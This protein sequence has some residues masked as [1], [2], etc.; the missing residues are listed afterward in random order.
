MRKVPEGFDPK[1]LVTVPNNLVTVF[2]TLTHDLSLPLPWPKPANYV[3]E[4]VDAP[5]L[6]WGG[7]SSVGQ[8]AIQVLK[9]WGYS[10]I[11]TTASAKHHELLKSLGAKTAVDYRSTDFAEKILDAAG[12]EGL[13]WVVDS[14]GS[15]EGSLKP[16]SQVAKNGTTVAVM[17]PVIVKDTTQG[18]GPI[19]EMDPTEGIEWAEGAVVKGVRTHFYLEVCIPPISQN[20]QANQLSMQNK[21][22]ADHLQSEIIPTLIKEGI[23]KP[24]KY[25]LVE[26]ET[27][28]ERAENALGLLRRKIPSAERLVWR[29]NDEEK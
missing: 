17:L 14:I 7:S 5:I 25:L 26:G 3:P 10:N 21:F 18:G 22:L 24:N 8:Y 29:V 1:S 9:Y 4:N 23:I 28:L 2:H 16:I 6:I 12:A 13:K 15:L 27:L 19:Y 20:P 11:I